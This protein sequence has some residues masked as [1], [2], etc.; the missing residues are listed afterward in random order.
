MK[1][2]KVNTADT[3]NLTKSE[4][5]EL[6]LTGVVIKGDRIIRTLGFIKRVQESTRKE[7]AQTASRIFR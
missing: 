2:P 4:W 6:R 5:Q 3:S 7:I 1:K